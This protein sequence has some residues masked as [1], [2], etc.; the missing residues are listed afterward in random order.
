MVKIFLAYH[1]LSPSY[2]SDIFSPIHV[3]ALKSNV[4]IPFALKDSIGENI[5]Y[6]NPY[7]CELTGHYWVLKNYIDNCDD[8]YIGFAHYRRLPDFLN[9][10][11]VDFPSI[12]GIGYN[13]SLE[14]FNKINNSDIDNLIK[15]Y[16]V[17]CPCSCYMYK[18]TVNPLLRDNEPNYNVYDHF[19]KE[20]SN[21]LLDRLKEIIVSKYPDFSEALSVCY[22][23]KKS[24]FY[25]IYIMKTEIMKSLL[26]WQFDVLNELGVIIGGWEQEQYKRMAGFVAETLF[27]IWITKNKHFNIGYTPIYM[28]DFEADYI[29]E[30]N[31]LHSKGEYEKEL[32]ILLEFS[33]ITNDKFSTYLSI[34]EISSVC[35]KI[36]VA[37]NYLS[38]AKE[39]AKTEEDFYRLAIYASE[40]NTASKEDVIML[41]EK[42]I[43]LNPQSKLFAST[44]LSY[45]K[46][47][48][49]IEI[50]SKAWRAMKAHD[51]TVNEKSDYEQFKKVYKMLKG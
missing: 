20:H 35:E 6:L 8:K 30:I 7:Y 3:G 25:N 34:C 39:Y 5:S 32:D 48:H 44:F 28:I 1:K 21:N 19:I 29:S 14:L 9:I 2:K 37:K 36:T 38:L 42:A 17:I 13:K 12:Y 45:A 23:S 41:F 40:S 49:D 51:L 46:K 50:T 10:S 47:L 24:Y 4:E 11:S 33:E 26:E 15:D 22:Q 31:D 16:D 27:S 18:N 43:E